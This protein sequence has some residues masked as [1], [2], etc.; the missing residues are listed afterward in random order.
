[1]TLPAAGRTALALGAILSLAPAGRAGLAA[2]GTAK[3][4]SAAVRAV[5]VY[6]DAATEAFRRND[7]AAID[8][9]LADDFVLTDSRGGRSGR[10]DA[11]REARQGTVRYT[12]FRNVDQQ[13]RLYLKGQA[14]VVTGRT[15]IAGAT[16]DGTPIRQDLPFTDT[17][18]RVR[19]RWRMVASHVSRP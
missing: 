5:L 7:A 4:D 12:E 11:V 2:Q 15:L 17:L 1:M 19:G 16:A 6:Q 9:L 10:A 14:A 18:V 8:T 13:V 3:A